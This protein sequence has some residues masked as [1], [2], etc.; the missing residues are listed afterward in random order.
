MSLGTRQILAPGPGSTQCQAWPCGSK[1]LTASASSPGTDLTFATPS[2]TSSGTPPAAGRCSTPESTRD[3]MHRDHRR[4]R[5]L[6]R[7][8]GPHRDARPACPPPTA[9]STAIARSSVCWRSSTSPCSPRSTASPS[10]RR[11]DLP[12]CDLVGERSNSTQGA[13]PPARRHDRGRRQLPAPADGCSR[14]L[15]TSS[16]PP[17]GSA[18]PT[19]SN[20]VWRGGSSPPSSCSTR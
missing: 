11:D 2:T 7:W 15:P 3:P 13:V 9:A 16:S 8:P 1:M 6:H 5:R 18:P 10:D 4:R 14:R 20:A 17:T 12:H 19:P